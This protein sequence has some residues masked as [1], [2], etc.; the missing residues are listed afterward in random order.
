MQHTRYHPSSSSR[1][2]RGIVTVTGHGVRLKMWLRSLWI[3]DGFK[4]EG[5]IRQRTLHRAVAPLERIL[6]LA[7]S[8]FVTVDALDWCGSENGVPIV[9]VDQSGETR[10]TLLPGKGGEWASRLRRAQALAPFTETGIEIAKWLIAR[11]IAGQENTLR[12]LSGSSEDVKAGLPDVERARS[13]PH[14]RS[15][16]AQAADAYWNAW[17]GLPVHF[18]PPSYAKTIPAHWTTF[19]GRGSPLSNG[20]RNAADP[21]NCLANYAYA[22]LE[23]EARIAI[24]QAGLDPYLGILHSDQDARRSLIYDCIEPVRPIADRLVLNLITNH[25][26]RPGELH[27]LRDGRTRLD[28]DL[29]ARLWPWMATFRKALGPVMTFLISRFRQMP[30]YTERAAFRLVET[31]PEIQTH[32]PLGQ[33]R[34]AREAGLPLIRPA[35][36]C[37]SCGVL[38]EGVTGR[39]Y[40]DACLPERRK[41]ITEGSLSAGTDKLR[42]LRRDGRDPAHGGVAAKERK[43]SLTRNRAQIQE[44]ERANARRDPK[45]FRRDILPR[46]QRVTL[47]EM[48]R[49]T[50]LC[51]GYCAM[52]R[53]GKYVPHPRHWKTLGALCG[54]DRKRGW[55]GNP[56]GGV[57]LHSARTSACFTSAAP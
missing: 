15:L 33:K 9:A 34:W 39:L 45:E 53:R 32:V 12:E 16:E 7:G 46:L 28:Q 41:E 22:L 47:R 38:L 54:F 4:S 23:A 42:E 20:P 31:T 48:M 2:P 18:A 49:A 29:C 5:E 55:R 26:F 25:A 17:K 56:G 24:Y 44:W 19:R 43:D 3:E 14:V 11:K 8:G 10:W 50:G 30:K 37:H 40:C 36:V 51:S 13:I 21:I 1:K 52:I 57:S 6:F 27:L 35:G